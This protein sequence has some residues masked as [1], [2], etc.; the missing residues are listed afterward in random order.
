MTNSAA[1]NIIE[2]FQVYILHFYTIPKGKK[3]SGKYYA[4]T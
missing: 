2:D 4:F 3:S 1:F